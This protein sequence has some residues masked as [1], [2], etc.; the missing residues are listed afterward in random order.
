MTMSEYTVGKYKPPVA[1]RFSSEHQP[2]NPGRKKKE[3]PNLVA[4][5][6]RVGNEMVTVTENKRP[7]RMTRRE[8]TVRALRAKALQGDVTAAADLL[9]LRRE[10]NIAEIQPIVIYLTENELKG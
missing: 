3:K 5:M 4:I 1:T 9:K 2:A 7:R 10:A 6:R 8:A